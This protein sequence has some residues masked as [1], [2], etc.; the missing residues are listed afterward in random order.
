MKRLHQLAL[1]IAY[2]LMLVYWFVARP[3][4]GG[5]YIGV[6]CGD[7]V[8]VIRNSYKHRW[9]L[10]AGGQKR[11]E[12]MLETAVRELR[13]EVAIEVQTDDLKHVGQIASREEYKDDVCDV[14]E[15][16]FDQVPKFVI[17]NTEVIEA[18]FMSLDQ[19]NES[20]QDFNCIARQYLAA[21]V[22]GCADGFD[23]ADSSCTSNSKKAQA[24]VRRSSSMTSPID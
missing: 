21:K 16:E 8:L 5:A 13:E 2:R 12:T 4:T 14:F 18:K 19:I 24:S 15:V 7:R 1:C 6:W 22:A 17:D 10:P 3:T 23:K 9:T 11:N 20:L